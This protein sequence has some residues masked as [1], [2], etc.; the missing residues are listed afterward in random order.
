MSNY[1]TLQEAEALLP[2]LESL[3]QQAVDARLELEDW[4]TELTEIA[5]QI[6][7]SGGMEIDPL[8]V[9]EVRSKH[10]RGA[11]HVERLVDEIEDTGCVVKDLE[12]GLVDFPARI[13]D[14]EVYLCWKLG[15]MSIDHWH[16]VNEGF[17][18]RKPIGN[19]FGPRSS[20]RLQ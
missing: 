8:R 12:T 5:A 18:G 7:M 16:G 19:E 13:G 11:V 1:F 9:S 6:T 17:S 4:E 20:S 10:K 14:Q 15:E 2:R 3:L